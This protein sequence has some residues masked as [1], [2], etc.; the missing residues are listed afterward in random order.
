MRERKDMVRELMD[1]FPANRILLSDL[2]AHG[3][4]QDVAV[5]M[6]G[7]IGRTPR[8]TRERAGR[9]HWNRTGI[10]VMAGGVLK[11]GQAIGAGDSRGE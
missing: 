2:E 8:I 1:L 3:M 9:N 10:T 4:L 6:G 7:E 5:I 11:T